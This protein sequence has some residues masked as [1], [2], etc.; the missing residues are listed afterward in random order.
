MFKK[1][2]MMCVGVVVA[3]SLT[4]CGGGVI[5]QGNVGVQTSFGDV[6]QQPLGTGFY[7]HPLSTVTEYTTKET[8][9][10]V[11]G[12]TPRAKDKLTM[13]ELD[14]TIYYKAEGATLP[15][16]QSAFSGQSAELEGDGF[17]RPGYVLIKTLAQGVVADE[18][19]KFDS[20]TIHQ[21]R[22]PLEAAIKAS[23][24]AQLD[25]R[26]PGTFKITSVVINKAL[27]DGS[28]EQSIRDSVAADNRL[29]TATKLVQVKEQEAKA[30][31]K[32]NQSL[33]PAFLEYQRIL[34][35]QNCAS[36]DKCTMIIDGGSSAKII[37]L[38]K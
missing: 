32:V 30:N 9:I 8:S 38:N 16:F 12:L 28:I 13:R 18:V 11:D 24:Q 15:R 5:D 14:A 23:L 35:Q 19:S 31:E 27:T 1:L 26:S 29:A 10:V 37:N 20:L 17:Y 3:A 36:S 2:L 22:V 7:W 33:T 25:Q 6:S 34:A 21:N 4:G